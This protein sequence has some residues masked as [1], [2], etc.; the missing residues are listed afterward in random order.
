M[1]NYVIVF[2]LAINRVPLLNL[3]VL[4]GWTCASGETQLTQNM[5]MRCCPL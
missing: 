4:K 5:F 1:V 2:N 3:L